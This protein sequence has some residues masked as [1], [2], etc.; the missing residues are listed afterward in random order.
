MQAYAFVADH[1]GCD[2]ESAW[3]WQDYIQLA[4]V[5]LPPPM[6]REATACAAGHYLWGCGHP[7][8]P[9]CMAPGSPVS[10][11]YAVVVI[12]SSRVLGR[13]DSAPAAPSPQTRAP[14]WHG[15]GFLTR[16]WWLRGAPPPPR[17]AGLQHGQPLGPREGGAARA[18]AVPARNRGADGP[19]RH[20]LV[21]RPSSPS[22]SRNR[23]LQPRRLRTAAG[24]AGRSC[25]ARACASL[26]LR[27][28]RL[29]MRGLR[30]R[31]LRM[32]RLRVQVRVCV[33]A[34]AVLPLCATASLSLQARLR[35]VRGRARR[36][37]ELDDAGG[38]RGLQP[39]PPAP[40]N[41]VSVRDAWCP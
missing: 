10:S 15:V 23:L 25:G 16:G 36:A 11:E 31:G 8:C 20:A 22:P 18:E 4:K 17:P 27:A 19:T 39:P 41:S 40:P 35:E 21:R 2:I 9:A 3:F 28:R 6:H 24:W 13:R 29:R 38:G 32:R 34:D 33:A 26:V 5:L 7:G 14:E 30:T 37:H 1:Y 12:V